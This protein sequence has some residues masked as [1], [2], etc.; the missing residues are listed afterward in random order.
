MP[1]SSGDR[2]FEPAILA[3][4]RE[5][6]GISVDVLSERLAAHWKEITPAV[7]AGW[8]LGVGAPTPVQVK[9][10]AEVYKRPLAVFLL[11]AP[12]EERALPPDRRTIGSRRPEPFS[13]P[14]LLAIRRARRAQDLTEELEEELGTRRSFKYAQHHL[15]EN[16]TVLARQVRADLSISSVDQMR[17]SKYSDFFQYLRE[18]LEGTGVLTL[19][20]AGHHGFPTADARALSFTDKE[21]YIILIN[22]KDTEGAKNFSL[23]HEFAHVLLRQAGIC[24]NFTAFGGATHVD[25]LEVFC[26]QFAASF[27][28]PD[29]DF[30]NHPALRGK[31]LLS[32]EELEIAIA[33][34]A[35]SF[36]VSRLVILRR[37]ST[38]GFIGND[39]Y[40]A[41]ARLWE[42]DQPPKRGGGKS[43]P[44]K[45]A[46]LNNGSTFA[47]LVF[48]AYRSERL[49]TSAASDY[50][51]M[52]T[53]HMAAF[54]RLLST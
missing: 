6:A 19:R 22:N 29:R 32:P 40:K 52:K 11:A 20:S 3:W 39:V 47:R 30:S 5:K 33:P 53:K 34:L 49:S 1:P 10:L 41:K 36:K 17:F 26:N 48:D 35:R 44:P 50:L 37:L 2:L 38:L 51:G 31:Q 27:L 9:W 25:P 15:R 18:K 45:T 8:E 13:P 16:P 14:A 24:N 7:V 28:V 4:A 21:P 43:S 23:A 42:V 46:L 54:E 12:P